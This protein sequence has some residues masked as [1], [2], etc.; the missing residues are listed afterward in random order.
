MAEVDGEAEGEPLTLE[1]AAGEY[2]VARERRL[3]QRQRAAVQRFV[4][5]CGP[6]RVLRSISAH[7]VTRF[8]EAQGENVTDLA[9]R[10]Q[11]LKE[12]FA[13]A[14]RREWTTTNLGVHLR[15]KRSASGARAAAATGEAA[16][17]DEVEMTAAGLTAAQ[18]ELTRLKGERPR[19]VQDIEEAMA[20]KDFREN[21]PLDAARD[22]QGHL[23][24]RIRDLEYQVGHAAVVDYGQRQDGGKVHLG[25]SVT[26]TNLVS[27]KGVRYT[28]VG[29][30][31]VDAS[32]GLIS[33][34]SPVGQAF[35][36]RSPGDVVEVTAPAGTIQ[37]RVDSVE[38]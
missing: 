29:Q 19:I 35:V 9:S 33:V 24:A 22:A 17:G 10:L 37:F 13:H 31:E 3:D 12:F 14:K 20:D 28:L 1:G 21:A 4:S 8:Q 34:A 5:W 26:V 11:P 2:F 32:A 25:S 16:A 15:L 30:N 18:A 36:G 27:G 7:E 23:E 6:S 38:G